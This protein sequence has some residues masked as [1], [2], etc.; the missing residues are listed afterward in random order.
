MSTLVNFLFLNVGHFFAHLMM[1]IYPV[2]ALV[3]AD[4][5]G[6]NY[7]DLLM[8]SIYGLVAFGAGSL[9]AGWLGDRWSRSAM[10]AVF[11]IGIGAAGV[12]VGMAQS[13]WQIA[14]ALALIGLF[15]SIYHPVGIAMLTST[16]TRLGRDLGINGVYGNFGV[17]F[18]AIIAAGLT[19][20][21]SW[22][23]AYIVPGLCAIATGVAYALLSRRSSVEAEV[24]TKKSGAAVI[25]LG[26]MDQ[27]RLLAVIAITG[28]AGGVIFNVMTIGLPKIFDERLPTIASSIT[29]VGGWV[30]AVLAIAGFSQIVIGELIDRYP[31][32]TV[33]LGVL[34]IE[35]PLHYIGA[36]AIDW[37]MLGTA[38]PLMLL[39]FGSIPI[40]DAI[41]ARYVADVWR[42]RVYAAKYVLTLGVSAL[43]VPLIAL[44]QASPEGFTRLFETLAVLAIVVGL[45]AIMLPGGRCETVSE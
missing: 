23:A 16:T 22:R 13:E 7:G 40:Y 35:A 30:T 18:A 12:L 8:L 38:L 2:V 4:D 32:K 31:F 9:P 19:E 25:R 34:V 5:L 6:R 14:A 11:F 36:T 43:A 10:M 3:L 20:M 41:V 26:R 21:I 37:M 42:A 33:F 27:F 29:E 28:A 1:L 45:S 15:G 44:F 17:A 24:V 39:V